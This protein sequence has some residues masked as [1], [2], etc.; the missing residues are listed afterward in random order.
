[1]WKADEAAVAKTSFP[2]CHVDIAAKCVSIV[3]EDLLSLIKHCL[4]WIFKAFVTEQR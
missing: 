4:G 1:M 2:V 3:S